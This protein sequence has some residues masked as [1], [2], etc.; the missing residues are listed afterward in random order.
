MRN[1]PFP[2]EC[3]KDPVLFVETFLRD[4]DGHPCKPHTGQIE[5]LRGMVTV[6]LSVACCGRQF[7]KSVA[8]GWYVVWYA[9]CHKNRQ[10]YIIAPTLDQARI[11]FNEV[12]FHFR[13]SALAAL[14]VGKMKEYPFPQIT[15]ANGT[16]IH[17]RG[18]NT[19]E[20]IRGKPI[21]L[22]I[23]DEAAF[24]KDG[25]ISKVIEPMFTVTGQMEHAGLC[26]ISTPFGQGDFYDYAERAKKADKSRFFHYTSMDNPYADKSYLDR[27]RTEY[28]EDSLLWQT[29][30]MARFVDD[31]LAV[32]PWAQIKRAI[33]RYPYDR[34]GQPPVPGHKY[35]SG[36][37]LANV[38][39]Y[40]V[41]SILDITNPALTPL[42]HYDRLQQ[43]GY[44]HYKRVLRAN[45]AAYHPK[46]L[47][48][49]TSLGESV[50]EDLRDIGAEGYKFSS[51]SK[52]EI[53]QELSR[54]LNENRLA[55]PNDRAIIDELR[56]FSY[57]ITA[58]KTLKMEARRGHDDIVMSLALA[59]HTALM[60]ITLGF[61]EGVAG[62]EPQ[63]RVQAELD[64][65]T[66]KD[67]FAELFKE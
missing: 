36:V 59:A 4:K 24:F 32:F 18:A 42:V 13:N 28:G 9:V 14:I 26:M 65:Y 20:Y 45:H 7:G 11:I 21:H 25:T 52:Y 40:F 38:R 47:I 62:W 50:V 64:E 49:A 55:L 31:D 67:P 1:S 54:M 10:I 35:V 17:A 37:D 5:L 60:P 2:P 39:D 63:Y 48:D 53:V 51:Q 44:A 3:Q 15:L 46:T 19:P 29:E 58:S 43:K 33:E 6:F 66:G 22:A 30:Y 61:F 12:S 34:C 16:Q 56:F 41:A 27:I 57:Q 8:M 23:L